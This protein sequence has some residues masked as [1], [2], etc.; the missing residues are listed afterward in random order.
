VHQLVLVVLVDLVAQRVLEDQLVLVLLE[1]QV[2]LDYQQVLGCQQSLCCL[3]IQQGLEDRELLGI[4]LIQQ[5]L[6]H[7]QVLRDLLILENRLD[8][9]VQMVLCYQ[10]T[11][12]VL[13]ALQN[14]FLVLRC[15]LLVLEDL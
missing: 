12:L 13:V 3:V 5:V 11:L 2:F 9:L 14:L 4:L 7:P 1:D 10:V 8:L 15:C 6:Y